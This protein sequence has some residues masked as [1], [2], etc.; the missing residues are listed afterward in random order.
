[1][2]AYAIS[3][4]KHPFIGRH[5]EGVFTALVPLVKLWVIAH[6]L[7]EVRDSCLSECPPLVLLLTLQVVDAGC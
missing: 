4:A 6:G 5:N 1:M 7:V 3:N 2:A